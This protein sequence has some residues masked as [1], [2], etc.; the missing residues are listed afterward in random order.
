MVSSCPAEKTGLETEEVLL[1]SWSAETELGW[2]A[3]KELGWYAGSEEKLERSVILSTP[4]LF[5]ELMAAENIEV[6]R[7]AEHGTGGC[8]GGAPVASLSLC[9]GN[10]TG[11]CLGNVGPETAGREPIEERGMGRFVESK[12]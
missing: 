6:E 1:Q 3:E 12:A 2:S 10:T 7:T 11:K 5:S 8:G 9:S 4:R